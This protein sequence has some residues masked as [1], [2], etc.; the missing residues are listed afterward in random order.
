M[1]ELDG[2]PAA[3]WTLEQILAA[4]REAEATGVLTVER[5]RE[6]LTIKLRLRRP[7]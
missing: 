3:G 4:F 7:V 1:V 5:Q 6:R 2:K